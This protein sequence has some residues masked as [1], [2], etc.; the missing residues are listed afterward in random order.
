[1]G[2]PVG[3]FGGLRFFFFVGVKGFISS[4]KRGIKKKW[5][6]G[7]DERKKSKCAHSRSIVVIV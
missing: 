1:M 3:V 7:E 6:K 2:V 4:S 5:K